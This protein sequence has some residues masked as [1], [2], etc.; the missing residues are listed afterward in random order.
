MA[1]IITVTPN[2]V[3]DYAVDADAVEANRKIRCKNPETHPGGGGINVARATSRLGEKTLAIFTVGGA[4]GEAL[5][6]AMAQENVP[7]LAIAV[8][9]E[10]RIALHVH[11][12]AD[13]NEYRF[14][15]PGA[16]WSGDEAERLRATIEAEAAAGDF[17]VGSG[18]LPPGAPEDFWAQVARLSKKKAARFVLDSVSGREAAIKEGFFLLR[19]NKFEY[20]TLAG[21][22]LAW[23]DEIISFAEGL[24]SAEKVECV[25]I[26]HGGDGSIMATRNGVA[27]V[28]ALPVT[29]NSAVGAGDSF[30]GGL[31]VGLLQGWDDETALR[32]GMCAAAA[33]RLTPGTA[34]FDPADVARLFNAPLRQKI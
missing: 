5:K 4:S 20:P 14:S 19:Q 17:I 12:I 32:Y 13:G 11:D 2:P 10:T 31:L 3:R 33:T 27:R 8:D 34:L 15:L 7:M 23:P 6:A 26:T 22:E 25:A 1:R 30:V 9:G 18:S 29:T 16:E 24:V 28:N 21:G